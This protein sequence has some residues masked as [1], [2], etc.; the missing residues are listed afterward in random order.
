MPIAVDDIR[1]IYLS[2]LFKTITFDNISAGVPRRNSKLL[3][4]QRPRSSL[5]A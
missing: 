1:R 3:Q 4:N 2:I 5:K